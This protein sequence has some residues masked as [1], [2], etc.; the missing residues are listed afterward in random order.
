M[1]KVYDFDYV[2]DTQTTFRTLMDAMS[3]PLKPYSIKKEAGG[4]GNDQGLFLSIACTL[5]DNETTFYVE[6]NATL[7]SEIHELTLSRGAQIKDADYIFL[8]SELNYEAIKAM[9]MSAKK[10]DFYDPHTSA[11]FIIFT[12]AQDTSAKI[13]GKGPGIKEEI[14]LE[15]SQ[16]V[17]QILAIRNETMVEYPC[18]IDLIFVSDLAQIMAC[19]RLI[20]TEEV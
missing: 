12:K 15:T 20:K 4:F 5:L 8:S 7:M 6:K 16:Y 10:G 13:V 17:K 18:G 14:Q 11:T 3:H 19:P 9:F 2:F 1:E